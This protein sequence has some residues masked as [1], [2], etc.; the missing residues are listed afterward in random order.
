MKCSWKSNNIFA[1]II[2]WEVALSGGSEEKT[3][4][5]FT[6]LFCQYLGCF[7]S[8]ASFLVCHFTLSYINLITASLAL[9]ISVGWDL[10]SRLKVITE[11]HWWFQ[12][13]KS[14]R[15]ES[16]LL[17]NEKKCGFRHKCVVFDNSVQE[18]FKWNSYKIYHVFENC[19]YIHQ[20][21]WS[22]F[23][24]QINKSLKISLKLLLLV[25]FA[26]KY[27][28]FYWIILILVITWHRHCQ[29]FGGCLDSV[30]CHTASSGQLRPRS[31]MQR[32]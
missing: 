12:K 18:H 15:L 26:Y 4:L 25:H 31:Q 9:W 24:T 22:R 19:W 6:V 16:N 10:Q 32:S 21:I 3:L 23:H 14:I 2:P 11:I 27:D 13:L 30:T 28:F 29:L 20:K 7:Y 17:S 8:W 1:V 5:G